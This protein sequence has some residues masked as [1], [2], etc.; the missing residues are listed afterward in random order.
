M[1]LWKC[2]IC[3]F[4]YNEELG[5]PDSGVTP[6]TTWYKLPSGWLCPKC[7]SYKA[8]FKKMF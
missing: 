5:L 8:Y 3:K 7:G 6:G 2:I 4:T 1:K